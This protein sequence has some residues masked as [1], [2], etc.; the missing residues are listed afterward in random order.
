MVELILGILAGSAV[1]AL[2][3]HWLRKN[4]PDVYDDAADKIKNA[5]K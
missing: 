1:T 5:G 2:G 3:L 4:K